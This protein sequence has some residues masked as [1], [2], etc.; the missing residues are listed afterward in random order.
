MAIGFISS[1]MREYDIGLAPGPTRVPD[2]VKAA[3]L[4]SLG[5]S[6]L[7][8]ELVHDYVACGELLKQIGPFLLLLLRLES[9][10]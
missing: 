1:K 8:E 9:C 5:S 2:D 4:T 10:Y 3:Y 6:V 7:E